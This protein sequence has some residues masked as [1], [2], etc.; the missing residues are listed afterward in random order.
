LAAIAPAPASDTAV[1]L[2]CAGVEITGGERRDVPCDRDVNP[3]TDNSGCAPDHD[4]RHEVLPP[5][6]TPSCA[7]IGTAQVCIWPPAIADAAK[8][9]PSGR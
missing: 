1:R 5:D 6:S 7:P 3:R 2:E 9:T 4:F 8:S